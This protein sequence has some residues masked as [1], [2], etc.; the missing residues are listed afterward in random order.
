M[1]DKGNMNSLQRVL[2]AIGHKEADRVPLMLLFSLY[3]AKELQLP[4]KEYFSKVDNVVSAQLKMLKKY[5]NDCLY[6]FTYAG[7]E[8][9]AQGG[10][11]LFSED[12]PPNCGEPIICDIDKFL[13]TTM[14]QISETKCLMKVLE[15]T[16]RLKKTVK[17][18][19]PIIAVVM[20]PFSIPVM[21]M[22]FEK[23]LELIY[24]KRDVFEKLMEKNIEFCVKWANAQL[25]S[26]ATAVC[27]FDPLASPTIIDRAT[28]LN[29]GY[30]AF[31]KTLSQIKGPTATHLASG[32]VMPVLND[33]I[34][35]GSAVVGFSKDD[36]LKQI[37]EAAQNKISL[38][39]NLNGIDMV[40]WSVEEAEKNVKEII[41][42][43]GK[44]GGLIIADNHGEIPCQV[45]EEVLLAISEAVQKWGNYPLS[46][47]GDFNEA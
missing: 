4:I 25:L 13:R 44:N 46:W 16:D 24:F 36:D 7:I 42:V 10:E 18:T 5:R 6:T 37:K 1:N 19:V 12:G 43:A 32:I 28:Y 20:S 14:P 11:V 3:G 31:K 22:G 26:G 35:A 8:I 33:I 41:R 23:Y 2:T 17:D 27:Y 47:I 38:L 29:T 21:Q 15:T 30:K 40:N 39:G 45:S 9:E 34:S